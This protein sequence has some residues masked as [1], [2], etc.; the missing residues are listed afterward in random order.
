VQSLDHRGRQFSWEQFCKLVLGR[1]GK[2]QYEVLIRQLFRI[3]QNSSV[4]EYI[5][6]FSE[7]VDELL[8]YTRNTD[9]L[10]FAMR[11]IDGLRDDICSAMHMQRPESFDAACVLAL[12]QEELLD[13]ARR[14]EGR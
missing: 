14:K 12:L 1:F 3:R 5:D 9:P 7:L 8:A 10:F 2:S 13:S 6:K 11:F 4:Q